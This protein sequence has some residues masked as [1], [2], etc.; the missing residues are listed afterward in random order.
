MGGQ[1]EQSLGTAHLLKGGEYALNLYGKPFIF[2]N[3]CKRALLTAVNTYALPNLQ[4][5]AIKGPS[6]S[7]TQSIQISC[8][9]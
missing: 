7:N 3:V 8:S 6:V 9:K 5:C 2:T 1:T 4:R